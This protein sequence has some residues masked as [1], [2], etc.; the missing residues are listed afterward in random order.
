MDD[1]VLEGLHDDTCLLMLLLLAHPTS[2]GCVGIRSSLGQPFKL[3][4]NPDKLLD[5]ENNGE[6][7]GNSPVGLEALGP[8]PPRPAA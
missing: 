1:G 8:S 3:S 6:A 7:G 4:A 5:R 2:G